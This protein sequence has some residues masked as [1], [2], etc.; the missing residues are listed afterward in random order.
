M[1]LSNTLPPVT[2]A[3]SCN[4]L[5][6]AS[7]NS[8]AK[9]LM[10]ESQ[11]NPFK[12]PAKRSLK[13]EV[14]TAR[15]FL[16]EAEPRRDELVRVGLPSTFI[17]EFRALV[18]AL[19]QAADVQV[20]SK[21]ARRLATAGINTALAE[22]LDAVRALDVAVKIATRSDPT[23]FAAWRTARH[24]EGLSNQRAKGKTETPAPVPP[25]PP[26]VPG[27]AGAEP[28]AAPDRAPEDVLRRVS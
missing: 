15:A 24:I 10:P 13:V 12:L 28:G 8:T 2:L 20:S 4:S 11:V 22:G 19:E 17:S 23:R 26:P 6:F 21:T 27:P 5:G 7:P 9:V 18:D 3:T 14:A 25:M 1:R 16:K